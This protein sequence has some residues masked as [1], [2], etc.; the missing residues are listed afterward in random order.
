MKFNTAVQ[1][2]FLI[3]AIVSL[4]YKDIDGARFAVIM[5]MIHGIS[6]KLDR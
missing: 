1:I 4:F 5:M 2:I 3:F 6:A